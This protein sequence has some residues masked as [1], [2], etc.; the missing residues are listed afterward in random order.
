MTKADVLLAC[1]NQREQYPRTADAIESYVDVADFMVTSM[2]QVIRQGE[3]FWTM[4]EEL[5]GLLAKM[6][7]S[8]YA[9]RRE[10]LVR[11][12]YEYLKAQVAY[13]K[14][15]S[16]AADS[17]DDVNER[18][19]ANPEVMDGFYLDGLLLTQAFWPG[20]LRIN[21]FYRHSFLTRLK[22]DVRFC[23]VGV[24]Q[25]WFFT[26]ALCARPESHGTGLDISPSS[27]SY[28]AA[29]AH[30]R[31]IN[32][33]RFE[34]RTEDAQSGLGLAAVS[35]DACV[36]GEVLEHVSRPV[37]LVR[38]IVDVLRPGGIAF[39]TAPALSDAVDHLYEFRS[40]KEVLDT[41]AQG[42]LRPVDHLSISL[43]EFSTTGR[44]WDPTILTSVVAVKPEGQR[45][46]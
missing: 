39:F 41:I 45:G 25:G 15:G 24:G 3:S 32:S 9:A 14:R 44:A 18:V 21:H 2:T 43:S 6:S 46:R 16:Y 12:S 17:F 30:A 22:P 5:L 34:L 7:G 8:N 19:Y 13:T 36:C 1:Q 20:H 10:S 29:L 31:E 42:G 35:M 40:A 37:E 28:T 4:A 11:Y 38:H 33:A 23:E 26:Q 27:L